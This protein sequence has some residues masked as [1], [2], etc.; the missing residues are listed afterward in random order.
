MYIIINEYN[1]RFIKLYSPKTGKCEKNIDIDDHINPKLQSET[2]K[3][4]T[5]KKD[6]I[7]AKLKKKKDNKKITIER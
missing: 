7:E 5:K 2:N 4:T 1:T 3:K 6:E